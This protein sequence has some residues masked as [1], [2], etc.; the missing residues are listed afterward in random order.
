M[1]SYVSELARR[2]VTVAL[3]GD[4]GDEN[5]FGYDRYPAVQ[6]LSQLS[7]LAKGL[8]RV[9][10]SALKRM[11]LRLPNHQ[12]GRLNQLQALFEEADKPYSQRYAFTIA[13]FA[14]HDKRQ[15][16]TEHMS[17]AVA[18]SALD[19]LDP[20]FAEADTMTTGQ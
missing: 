7:G 14:D 1:R 3:N 11:P 15:G 5:F 2:N 6:S 4:G 17:E 13:Y 8:G 10:S 18:N 16:Y 20:Y 9:V 12:Q 19:L